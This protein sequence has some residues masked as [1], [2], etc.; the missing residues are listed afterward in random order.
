[1]QVEDRIVGLVLCALLL[2]CS[3]TTGPSSLIAPLSRPTSRAVVPSRAMVTAMRVRF[4][5]VD[6]DSVRAHYAAVDDG[7]A[8][9]TP[10]VSDRTGSVL[11]PWLAHRFPPSARRSIHKCTEPSTSRSE[12]VR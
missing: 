8:G 11:A 10:W 12:N 5:D 6:A 3:D 4:T 7:E 1:M 9:V 2:A